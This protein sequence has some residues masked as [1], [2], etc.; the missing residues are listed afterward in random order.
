MTEKLVT[1]ANFIYGPDP[2]SQAEIARMR[3]EDEGIDCFLAGK[4]FVSMYWLYSAADRGIKLQ[5]R[6][7]DA[8]KA[9]EI[10]RT[11]EKQWAEE[12]TPEPDTDIPTCPKCGSE[13]FEYEKFSKNL[14]YLAILFF[15]FPLPYLTRS[16]KC[17]NC[18]HK[19]K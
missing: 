5:V 13:N 3:L 14:F 1:I 2:A 15:R 16:N 10:I 6:Q 11:L 8:Q 19:W 18:H 12:K 17:S 9:I 7:Y 4:N